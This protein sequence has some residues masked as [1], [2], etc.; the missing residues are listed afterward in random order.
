M[1]KGLKITGLIIGSLLVIIIT[2][3]LVIPIIFKDKIKDKVE[4]EINSMVNAR[5][6]FSGYKLSLFRAFPNI[7]FTLKDLNVTG[8]DK[9]EGDTLAAV[10]SFSL[11]FNLMSL[12]GDGGYEIRS[13]NVDE[14]LV[15]AIVLEDGMANWDIIKESDEQ[16]EENVADTPGANP[17]KVALNRFKISDGRI[18]YTDRQSGMAA[19]IEELDFNLSGNLS[20]ARSDIAL[21]LAAGSVDLIMDKISYLTDARVG[22]KAEIDALTDSMKFTLRDNRFNIN[23]IVL[24]LSGTAAMPGDDI[25][26]DLIFNAPE[27]SF[28]SL[29]SLVP[30]FYMK[31]Y[32]ELK[33]TGTFTLDGAVKGTYSSAD[34]TL[35]DITAN[36]AVMEGVI[37]YPDLPEKITAIN[38]NGMVQTDG[39]E[40][41]NTTVD[42]SRFHFELAGNPFDMN[43]KLST[44][45]SDPSVKAA[46]RGRIDL[47]KLQQA[48]PLDSISLNGLIDVSLDL[49][50]RMSMLENKMYDQFNAAGNLRISDMSMTMTDMPAL[51]ISNAAFEFSPAF[52]E[53]TGMAATM[54]DKSDFTLSGRL[55]NYIP[56]LFSDG[57]LKGN[58]SLKSKMTDLNEILD[59]IPSDT[60]DTDTAAMEVIQIPEN[61]DFTF[62][63]NLDRLVYGRL[64]ATDVTGNI[65]VRDGVVT[66]SETGMKT[67]G[68]TMLMNASYDTRDTLKPLID[69]D[70]LISAVNIRETFDAFN[71]VRQLIPAA[72]GLGGNV[73]VKM[74]FRSLLNG[75]MMPLLNTMSGSGELNSESVQIVESKTFDRIKSVLKL[76]Q[77]YTNI[78]K[79]IKATFIVND[80]RLFVKPFD[81]K[82]GNIKLNVS[83]DQGIDRTINYLIMTEIPS[84]DLGES[85]NALMGAF[86]TQLAALGLNLT[87]PEIIKINL[88][89][90]G[91]F[92]DPV[93]TPVFAGSAGRTV[94]SVAASVAD[95][96]K[97][98]VV[99]KVNEAARQQADKILNEAEE[100]AQMLRDEAS[101]SAG[102]IRSE[103]DL[104]GKKLVKDAEDQGPLAVAAARRTAEVLNKEA[105]KRA[106]QLVTEANGRADKILADAKAKAEELLK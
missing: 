38:I 82:L 79:D 49:A 71:T 105:E 92:T 21:D 10:K 28:K 64:A 45:L 73:T 54:G 9:F 86:S 47:A 63:A 53:L 55:E 90:G 52:A 34:S 75:S 36:L 29:L 17:L 58:L 66:V 78:V 106:T 69:A 33:A 89:L 25:D 24:N 15:N 104:R 41:D 3:G 40:M 30:A 4:T 12:L 84:A 1:K 85:A 32:E 70:L 37:S 18:F 42:V 19:A 97:Q 56:Y 87:P 96:V 83:G 72:A 62:S 61:M 48:I 22:F 68:G 11:V 31:D 51:K 46:A 100:K 14:L 91:T 6:K 65:L 59:I 20:A 8:V 23:D 80:G 13:V 77:S 94:T 35:P 103:A 57:I 98:E 95:T 16:V 81:T 99:E 67:L 102:G 7:S 27:T 93:I 50:G 60:L 5:V 101:R 88:R 76:N 44:P 74:D 39:R 26:L 43:L 2:A